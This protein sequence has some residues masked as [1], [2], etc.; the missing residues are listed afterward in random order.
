[1]KIANYKNQLLILTFLFAVAL[2]GCA[3]EIL[4]ETPQAEPPPNIIFIMADDLGYGDLGSYGQTQIQTPHLDRFASEGVRFTDF[5]AGSTVCAPSRSVLMT[6]LHTGHTYIRGN[7]KNSFR[8]EEV[9]VAEVLKEA[10]YATG[11]VGKW[12]LGQEG[13]DGVPTR[14]GFDYFF[15]Y[16][17]QTHAHNYYP[18]FL[19]RNEERV[20]LKNVVPDEGEYGQGVASE[21]IEYSHN[22][23]ADETLRFVEEHSQHPFFLYLALTLPHANNQAGDEGMEVPDLGIYADKDW[24]EA[25]KGTAAMISLVDRDVGRLMT[26]LKEK[27]IDENTLVFFTSD[28][29]PHAEGG[30][31]PDF[32]DSNGQLRGIKRDLYEGGIRVPMLV[33]WPGKAPAG[34][35]SSHVGYFGD[36]M[37]T[38]AEVARIPAPPN[39]DS[40]SFLPAILGETDRQ[41]EHAY[42]Y[43]EFYE[44]GSAQAIRMGNWKAVRK[45][46]FGDKIELFNLESDTGE[47]IDV[48]EGFPKVVAK[49]RQLME[50]A[51]TPAPLWKIRE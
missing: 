34:S 5:Y 45:P 1:M 27:G 33:R 46:M 8:P 13:S 25:Q 37:A 22:L 20:S 44:R 29:G 11:L 3:R 14:Q 47:E 16:L 23:I 18:S 30:N 40:V 50:E 35:V 42:L 12:G 26:L 19:I 9:T 15:G 10:G 7:S 4:R 49:A 48:S 24:P 41:Q 31:D 32:F 36:F 2:T 39:L 43:W 28:N 51:H 6:G 17:D 38:A 21:K